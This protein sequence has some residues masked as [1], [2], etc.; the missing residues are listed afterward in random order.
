VT[1]YHADTWVSDAS[2]F[3][4]LFTDSTQTVDG[5]QPC[6]RHQLDCNL[7]VDCGCS[8]SSW[9]GVLQ[10]VPGLTFPADLYLEGSDQHRGEERRE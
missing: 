8:G 10:T 1:L 2:Q 3:T 9:A 7:V 4:S 5:V 6:L